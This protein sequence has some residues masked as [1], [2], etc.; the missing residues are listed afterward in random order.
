MWSEL[1]APKGS[2]KTLFARLAILPSGSYV[3]LSILLRLP[4]GE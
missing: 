4:R 2:T 1:Y 3:P